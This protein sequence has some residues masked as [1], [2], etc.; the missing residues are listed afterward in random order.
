MEYVVVER[1]LTT[2]FDVDSLRECARSGK[3]CLDLHGVR[4]GRAYMRP[5][6][7]RLF[8]V[9][10]ASDTEA[11]RVANRQ[12]GMPFDRA[13]PASFHEPPEG[14][15]IEHGASVVLVERTFGEPVHFADIQEQEERGAWCL[16]LHDVR[17]VHTFFSS[18][19]QR[20][21]CIYEAP[22]A[23][24]V[25]LANQ[26]TGVPFDTVWTARVVEP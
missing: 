10:R 5:D 25:R 1:T 4:Y 17:F 21:I 8:C 6:G 2:P 26:K 15:A 20:M 24:A 23:E 9:F 22:D 11:V 19:R 13:Y 18:D 7:L 3:G 12:L 14:P 16:D